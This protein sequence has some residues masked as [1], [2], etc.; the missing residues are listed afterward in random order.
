MKFVNFVSLDRKRGYILKSQ[1]SWNFVWFVHF[2]V[3]TLVDGFDTFL[4]TDE[5]S[6]N[7]VAFY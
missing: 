7:F 6:W 4:K 3:V 1:Q 5:K 2:Y